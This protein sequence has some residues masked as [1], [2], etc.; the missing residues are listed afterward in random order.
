MLCLCLL[1]ACGDSNG[2]EPDNPNPI[3][4]DKEVA[5]PAGTVKLSMRSEAAVGDSKT[6]LDDRLYIDGA[7]NFNAN[8]GI[9]VDLGGMKGLGNV[10]YIPKTG[11]VSKV[12]VTP[13]N[14]YIWGTYDAFYRI[15]VTNY[16][17]NSAGE[18]IGAD[19]KYQKPFYGK[20]EALK[21]SDT[22]LSASSDGG[23]ASVVFENNS[24]IPFTVKTDMGWVRAMRSST[25]DYSVLTNAI[26]FYI[27]PA[28]TTESET[29]TVTATTYYNKSTTITITRLGVAPMLSI[30]DDA[31]N[32]EINANATEYRLPITTN[33]D[34]NDLTIKSS[35]D[36][37]TVEL[38]DGS[39]RTA[40]IAN[41]IRWIGNEPAT[42]SRANNASIRTYYALVK[43]AANVNSAERNASI[44]VSSKDGK[45]SAQHSLIQKG[46]TV[47][48]KNVSTGASINDNDI[49]KIGNTGG[50]IKISVNSSNKSL[51]VTSDSP[52]AT[53]SEPEERDNVQ[54]YTITIDPSEN[55]DERTAK[56]SIKGK[57]D[58]P[59]MSFS[60]TQSPATIEVFN[61]AGKKIEDG[62]TIEV[63][64]FS[65][66]M[67]IKVRSSIKNIKLTSNASWCTAT[68]TKQEGVYT[69]YTITIADNETA[70]S[71]LAKIV[72]KGEKGNL[73]FNLLIKQKPATIEV[74]TNKPMHVNYA[75]QNMQ[76]QIKTPVKEL[77]ILC[78]EEWITLADKKRDSFTANIAENKTVDPR[79]ATIVVKAKKASIKSEVTI[80]QAAGTLYVGSIDGTIDSEKIYEIDCDSYQYNYSINGNLPF[81]IKSDADWCSIYQ[82]GNRF[83]VMIP[84]TS[85]TRTA[86]VTITGGKQPIVLTYKQSKW[87]TGDKYGYATI[88][89]FKT[90]TPIMYMVLGKAQWSTQEINTGATSKENGEFNTAKI[91][92]VPN[93]ENNYPAF[94]LIDNLN[95]GNETGWYM[96]SIS[97]L[98]KIGLTM[99]DNSSYNTY[100]FLS[101]TEAGSSLV[102]QY[103]W[104]TNFATAG[105][106]YIKELN[107]NL[108]ISY[109]VAFK[110]F[111]AFDE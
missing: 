34:F 91:H 19:I 37:A 86:K 64:E 15:Y 35:A 101:S 95:S 17:Q 39:S 8:G 13:G 62:S 110:K 36:W 1:P 7:D 41:S 28:T 65:N 106:S 87:K 58:E 77:E 56:I 18:I 21:P 73:S 96:P 45:L 11:Y 111:N 94:K 44:T 78:S 93:W 31:A 29:A 90:G 24:I 26:T 47:S 3:N 53:I 9:I 5:D 2:D 48:V 92:S 102:Y 72:I 30:P 42:H 99:G 61:S 66:S 105:Y 89:L 75:A 83:S 20:D 71:R 55:A 40:A 69:D 22:S 23:E 14:G 52:W 43:V 60:I 103:C 63:S 70:D 79:S 16:T 82:N 109:V 107:K 27:E 10:G 74:T 81:E 80:E 67:D 97:E 88:D 54:L 4:P 85:T 59:S 46:A 57:S 50:T 51:K 68:M 25:L 84:N 100:Y 38:V 6:K 98:K 32:K 33:L 104:H 108:N 76:F 49:L 12:A